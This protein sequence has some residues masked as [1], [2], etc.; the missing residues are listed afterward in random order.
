[1]LGTK[2]LTITAVRVS[3]FFP[4]KNVQISNVGMNVF[5]C[6][7]NMNQTYQIT[8]WK[9]EL[10]LNKKKC[11]VIHTREPTSDKL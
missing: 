5:Y 7:S 2:N 9:G 8:D 4:R 6:S 10:K 3:T 1:M 11:R